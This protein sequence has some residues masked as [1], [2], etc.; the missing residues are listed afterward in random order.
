MP[1]LKILI[2]ESG[3]DTHCL[4]GRKINKT[5]NVRVK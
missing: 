5:S 1:A 4:T 3:T 2:K